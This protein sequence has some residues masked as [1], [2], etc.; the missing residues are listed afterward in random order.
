MSIKQIYAIDIDGV[1]A[2]GKF[3]AEECTPRELELEA[4]NDLY[5]K[6]NI[7]IYHT[8]R[9]PKYYQMTYAWLVK[10]EAYFHALEMGKLTADVYIDDRNMSVADLVKDYNVL[11]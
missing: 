3:W 1:V 2:D 10:H 6:G 9:H 11:L 5:K 8:A 4:V 7:I